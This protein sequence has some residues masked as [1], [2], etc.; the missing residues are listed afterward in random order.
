MSVAWL[1]LKW[2]YSHSSDALCVPMSCISLYFARWLVF[3]VHFRHDNL[4]LRYL[5]VFGERK[6]F[7]GNP[8][9]QVSVSVPSRSY[10]VSPVCSSPEDPAPAQTVAS[11]CR[12]GPFISILST[13]EIAPRNTSPH[14]A[15]SRKLFFVGNFSVIVI[16]RNFSKRLW[17]GAQCANTV[18]NAI[19]LCAHTSATSSVVPCGKWRGYAWQN[20]HQKQINRL[21]GCINQTRIVALGWGNRTYEFR[22][23]M[24]QSRQIDSRIRMNK[25][26]TSGWITMIRSKSHSKS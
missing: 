26:H 9:G 1:S 4:L 12:C 24:C 10:T 6:L 11:L 13:L 3:P 8:S 21:S 20:L 15:I 16:W 2:L 14:S 23:K 5:G 25:S 7:P 19:V 22:G 18:Y 17:D